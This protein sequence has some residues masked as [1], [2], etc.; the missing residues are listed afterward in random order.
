LFNKKFY[1]PG[2]D[3][4]STCG[5]KGYFTRHKKSPAQPT[6]QLSVLCVESGESPL[7]S[8]ESIFRLPGNHINISHTRVECRSIHKFGYARLEQIRVHPAR[9]VTVLSAI[10]CHKQYILKFRTTI[11]LPRPPWCIIVT[12]KVYTYAGLLF[13]QTFTLKTF[14]EQN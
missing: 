12:H 14:F 2:G 7:D 9:E 5:K 8:R 6:S 13:R 11:S 3:N 1:K 4:G 10:T